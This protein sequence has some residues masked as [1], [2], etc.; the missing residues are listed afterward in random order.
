MQL[1]LVHLNGSSRD[2]LRV[3]YENAA[4]AVNDAL[5]ALDDSAPNA[6]DYYPLSPAA[7]EAARREHAARVDKVRSVHEELLSLFNHVDSVEAP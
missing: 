4:R 7:Y 6:R 5:R 3:Q 1:P 2:S